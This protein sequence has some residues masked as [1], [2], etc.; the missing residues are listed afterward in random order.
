MKSRAFVRNMIFQC[1]RR[2]ESMV[3]TDPKSELYEDM[4]VYLEEHGYTVKVFNLVNPPNSDSWNCMW[5]IQHEELMAQ[6]CADVII[7]N[8]SD[9]KTDHFWDMSELN[10]LKALILYV[11]MEKMEEERN[12]GQVYRML[13]ELSEKEMDARFALLPKEHPA[14]GPYHIFSR[15]ANFI[16][17]SVFCFGSFVMSARILSSL[18]ISSFSL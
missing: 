12:L 13:A 2:G 10:L 7:K 16:S 6:T 8:T 4:S 17:I 11:D 3:L 9:G 18:T 14:K 15:S 5:E 1:V